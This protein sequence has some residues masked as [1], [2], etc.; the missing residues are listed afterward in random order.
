MLIPEKYLVK[1]ET[2]LEHVVR[3]WEQREGQAP[4]KMDPP[5]IVRMRPLP[6]ILSGPWKDV[7]SLAKTEVDGK[8][9]KL[10]CEGVRGTLTFPTAQ[11]DEVKCTLENRLNPK[12][13]FGV[14]ASRWTMDVPNPQS[15]KTVGLE[16]HLKLVN[17]GENAASKMPDAK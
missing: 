17:V 12:S 15:K 10:T 2:P 4:V 13:P 5:T 16:L 6:L 9:G 11:K 7:R 3:A 8:L 14:V 1:G